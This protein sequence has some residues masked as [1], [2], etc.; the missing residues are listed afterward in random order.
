MAK[1]ETRS[2]VFVFLDKQYRS[3][4]RILPELVDAALETAPE[5]EVKALQR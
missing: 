2:G 5:M 3:A 1:I 4:S